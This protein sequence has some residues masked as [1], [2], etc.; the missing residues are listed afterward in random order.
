MLSLNPENG[1]AIINNDEIKKGKNGTGT[2][3]IELYTT[4]GD[5]TVD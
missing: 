5:I 2:H 3:Q 4:R 1:K